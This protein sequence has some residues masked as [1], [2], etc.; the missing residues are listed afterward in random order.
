MEF[1]LFLS[2]GFLL[3]RKGEEGVIKVVEC[4]ERRKTEIKRIRENRKKRAETRSENGEKE[5][6]N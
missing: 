3:K 4:K 2:L 1:V 6:N 5:E